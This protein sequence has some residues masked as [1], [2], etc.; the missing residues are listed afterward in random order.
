MNEIKRKL[1]KYMYFI[2]CIVINCTKYI[3]AVGFSHSFNYFQT[4]KPLNKKK[5]AKIKAKIAFWL[6]KAAQFAKN[7]PKGKDKQARRF[8]SCIIFCVFY[9]ETSW[10]SLKVDTKSDY[11][12]W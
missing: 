12:E 6:K 10:E 11:N 5:T 4:N 3:F 1:Q 2:C 7:L 8:D 9:D